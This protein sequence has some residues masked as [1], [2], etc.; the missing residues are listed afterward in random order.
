MEVNNQ[1]HS[2]LLGELVKLQQ[3]LEASLLLLKS[4]EN[5]KKELDK[6]YNNLT[7]AI[8]R[9][10]EELQKMLDNS[11]I[12]TIWK[13]LTTVIIVATV[14]SFMYLALPIIETKLLFLYV[15]K[16]LLGCLSIPIVTSIISKYLLKIVL[17]RH[18]KK[19]INSNKYQEIIKD[20]KCKEEERKRV[21]KRKSDVNKEFLEATINYSTQ[22][23]LV[24][25]KKTEIGRLKNETNDITI[26]NPSQR[27]EKIKPF[28]RTKT[29]NI[30]GSHY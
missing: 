29:K 5:E 9:K 1:N 23:A 15:S 4:K 12:I 22:N 18:D 21:E 25:L 26:N 24:Q 30:N 28:T 8:A 13:V 27:E 2:N 16:V 17:K 10:N 14:I 19:I 6:Y 3:S 20:I 7:R 11:T